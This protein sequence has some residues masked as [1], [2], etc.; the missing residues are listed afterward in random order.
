MKFDP[1]RTAIGLEDL[2]GSL[3]FTRIA[4]AFARPLHFETDPSLAG[5]IRGALGRQLHAIEQPPWPGHPRAYDLMFGE[6]LIAP[7]P[8]GIDF[9]QP[10]R[11]FNLRVRDEGHRLV[12]EIMLHGSAAILARQVRLALEQALAGGIDVKLRGEVMA[13]I[14]ALAIENEEFAAEPAPLVVPRDT[15]VFLRSP[16]LPETRG[17]LTVTS[18]RLL[19][20]LV[21]RAAGLAAWNAGNLVVSRE[22]LKHVR[23]TLVLENADLHM[24]MWERA[25]LRDGRVSSKPMK[26]LSGR[27]HLKTAK[28]DHVMLLNIARHAQMGAATAFGLGVVDIG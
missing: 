7:K 8:T 15:F 14:A 9:A 1:P 18:E 6:P 19:N 17:A 25:S 5:R 12:A 28:P 11:C 13:R 24:A 4:A 27:L 2:P 26:G 20:G 3:R 23:E 22:T 21:A 16:W 10:C